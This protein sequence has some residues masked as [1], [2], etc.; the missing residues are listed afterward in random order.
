MLG[1]YIH[2]PFCAQK[3]NYCD[4]NSYKI[5]EKNQKTDYLI[6]IRKEMELYKE[7][8][9]SKEFTSVFL[10]GGTPS[11]LTPEELT[12][13]ME[14]IYSNFNIG[15]DAEITMECNPGTLDKVK[16][17]AIKSLGI[18]RLSM[19]LQVTQDH[20]LKYIGRIHTYEQF[21]KNYKDAIEVG[22]NNINVDLMYSLPNQSFDEWKETLN[23]I[24]NLNPSHISA[25][26]LILEEGTKFYDMYLNKEFE[27]NDEEVD[28]NIYNYTID[29]LCKNGYHQYEISNY[30][31]EGY[32]CKHNIV[33]WKCD[34]YLGLGPGASGYINN[35]RYSNI[36]DIKG[37]NKCLEY[38]KR[39]I[40]EKNILSKKDE[41][42]EFIFM[43]LRMNKGINLDEFYKRFN[44]DFKHRYNDILGKLKNLNLIIE[45]NNNII[46][47]QRGREISNTV[48]VEFID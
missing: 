35:Y 32:E 25:Y 2:V 20:H 24:I 9:K 37:Y 41:M 28:I 45:Q 8:F 1:L 39:P 13:L 22:I 33:Y 30:S 40:E 18:N 5:E 19:G 48:F 31:K 10:G 16:L 21:E 17:K 15:K 47:T 23:K 36:C 11:I 3:C 38:D 44:I 7:E 12:T 4:F 34:N 27:L 29:T 14:N 43:G 42:E 6:S 46:L 26:S